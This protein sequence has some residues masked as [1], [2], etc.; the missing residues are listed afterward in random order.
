MKERRLKEL[1]DYITLHEMCKMDELCD[2]FSVSM[3][4]IRRDIDTL[5][6]MGVIRKVY[7]GVKLNLKEAEPTIPFNQREVKNIEAKEY[8]GKIAASLVDD[9]DTIFIDSGTT[10]MLL[11]RHITQKKV[12]IITNNLNVVN[13]CLLYNNINVIVCG[14]ELKRN[15]NSFT[16]DFAFRN[17]NSINVNKAFIA[18]TGASF[19][20]GFSNSVPMETPIKKTALKKSNK[21]FIMLDYS[22]WDVTSLMTFCEFKKVNGIITDRLP[23]KP[24]EKFFIKNNIKIYY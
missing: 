16:G 7:G 12:N 18:A 3:A 20:A 6:D 8:I 1:Q 11:I 10:T 9:N 13:E 5:L 21:S 17:L 4:T 22:K 14:G 23:P 2:V 19:E 24:Y 15:T